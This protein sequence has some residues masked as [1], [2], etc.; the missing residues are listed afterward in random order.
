MREKI[1]LM[2]RYNIARDCGI[3]NLPTD[4]AIRQNRKSYELISFIL[5]F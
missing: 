2:L 1:P 4:I 5:I 3:R